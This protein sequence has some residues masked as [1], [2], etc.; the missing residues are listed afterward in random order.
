MTTPAYAEDFVAFQAAQASVLN[1]LAALVDAAPDSSM[2]ELLD[3]Y[4]A[5]LKSSMSSAAAN[6]SIDSDVDQETAIG[7]A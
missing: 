2:H 5:E 1:E 4:A 7:E 3:D 6:A